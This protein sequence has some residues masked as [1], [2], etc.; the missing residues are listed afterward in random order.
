MW[1]SFLSVILCLNIPRDMQHGLICEN[2]CC[3]NDSV[4]AITL[5]TCNLKNEVLS[6]T[7]LCAFC[8]EEK[9]GAYEI[10][11]P[12]VLILFYNHYH[13]VPMRVYLQ[14]GSAGSTPACRHPLAK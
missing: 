3:K 1:V 11:K 14:P 9:K 5:L 4:F 6:F 8:P 7:F 2:L 10:T 12:C 13:R